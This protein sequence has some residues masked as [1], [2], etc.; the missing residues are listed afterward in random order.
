MARLLL[1]ALREAHFAPEI[2]SRLRTH[3]A[4]GDSAFQERARR[5]SIA[6]ADRL[7]AHY[8]SLANAKRPVLWFTYHVYYKAPDWIGPLVAEAL[9]IPYVVAEG[10]RAPKRAEGAWS[11][12]HRAAEQA[13]DRAAL[14][15]TMTEK[16]RPG[17]ETARPTQ[18]R[19][20]DLP[21]FLDET[22]WAPLP[23]R[24]RRIEVVPRLLTVAMMRPGDKSE[25]Y[26]ILAEALARLQHLPWSLDIVGDGEARGDV[27]TQFAMLGSRARFHGA[28]D[29]ERLRGLYENAAMLVWPAVNE[30]YGMALLEAQLFGNPVVAGD[31]GGVA[32]VVKHGET[33]ILTP[34]GDVNAFARSVGILIRDAIARRR[35][36]ER[37]RDFVAGERN[38]AQGAMRLR[39][40]LMPLIEA[41]GA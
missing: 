22:E 2:A 6:E 40:A 15:F 28:C 35:M 39:D 33:G 32:S 24:A 5:D 37:A 26:R 36:G 41:H 16:D 7:I 34:P 10:S 19:L 17:L 13:L 18:Q 3:D 8:R 30:A 4:N 29:G 23:P 20:V 12:G 9:S 21:P 31:F 11:V 27:E 14:I 1:R 38:L 25:S